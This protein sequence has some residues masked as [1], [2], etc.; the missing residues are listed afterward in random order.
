MISDQ[1]IN[2]LEKGLAKATKDYQ[3]L[4]NQLQERQTVLT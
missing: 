1:I 3:L 2:K 4:E